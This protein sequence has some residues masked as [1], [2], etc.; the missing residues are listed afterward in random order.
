M[1]Y[2]NP[3]VPLYKMIDKFLLLVQAFN[4]IHPSYNGTSI[5]YECDWLFMCYWGININT[6][7]IVSILTSC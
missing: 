5:T 6:P 1:Y 4:K 7:I 3:C 2:T